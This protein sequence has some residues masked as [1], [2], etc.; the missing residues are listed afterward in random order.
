MKKGFT[1]IE[2]LAVI[3]ILAIIALI[4]TPIIL[5]IIGDSKEQTI[6]ESGELYLRAVSTAITAENLSKEFN[7]TTCEV[8][9][10]GNLNCNGEE[11]IIETKGERPNSGYI[12]LEEGRIAYVEGLLFGEYKLKTNDN[13]KLVISES[14]DEYLTTVPNKPN[15]M[16]DALTP[17]KYNGTNWVITSSSDTSWYNYRKQEWANAVILKSGLEKNIG[18]IVSTEGDNVEVIAMFVWIPRY[19]YKIVGKYGT[20]MDGTTGTKT[21]PGT[22]D[23][24]F[25]DGSKTTSEGDYILHS[26]F[27]FGEEELSGFWVGKFETTGDSTNPT[28]LPSMTSLRDQN[29]YSQF[30]T[31]TRFNNYIDNNGDSHMM[32]NSEWGAVAYL[33]QSKYGKYAFDQTEVY[34]NNCSLFITGIAGDSPQAESTD[35]CKNT[36]STE[37]GQKASTTGN[38]T[39]VYDMSGGSF[40]RVMGYLSTAYLAGEVN[41]GATSTGDNAKFPSK[42]DSKYFDEFKDI[43]K[44]SACNGI[45]Y[46]QGLSETEKWYSDRSN[47]VSE[48]S[49][50]IVRGGRYDH[51]TSAGI[52]YSGSH[53][54][55]INLDY[56]F[57]VTIS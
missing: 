40:D 39:G 7:P 30:E 49:P 56:A 29:L 50:W 55:T 22:I 38:I 11:L 52:F 57:R 10:D 6:L 31:S 42:P 1:L 4:S 23:I 32:K 48:A 25:V 36:Y 26:S 51:T 41:W 13:K 15:L 43:D 54:G 2:L 46:G 9:K 19:E 27:T 21:N 37:I 34:I 24:K 8:K 35:V 12:E 47:F 33:S 17:V 44:S 20:H 18:D 53:S 14:N 28:I 45:C 5:G 3:V 16:N